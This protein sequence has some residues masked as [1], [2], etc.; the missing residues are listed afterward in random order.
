MGPESPGQVFHS[1]Y[2]SARESDYMSS[3]PRYGGQAT[4]SAFSPL[5]LRESGGEAGLKGSTLWFEE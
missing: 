2:P 5:E 1:N 4:S 3:G